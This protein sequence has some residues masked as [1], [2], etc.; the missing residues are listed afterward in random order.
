M[1]GP[2]N[3]PSR[4]PVLPRRAIY[5]KDFHQRD[6]ALTGSGRRPLRFMEKIDYEPGA[7]LIRTQ[8]DQGLGIQNLTGILSGVRPHAHGRLDASK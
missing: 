6:E 3:T 8:C 5:S 2:I 1:T 4:P 7:W